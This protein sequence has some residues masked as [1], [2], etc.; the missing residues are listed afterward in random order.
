M[1]VPSLPFSSAAAP[2]AV[3]P[4]GFAA[5]TASYKTVRPSGALHRHVLIPYAALADVPWVR[6]GQPVALPHLDALLQRLRAQDSVP[7]QDTDFC[8]S[9]ERMAALWLGW[10][11]ARSAATLPWAAQTAQVSVE[12]VTPA[13]HWAYMTPCHWTVGAD[14][15]RLD[16]PADLALDAAQSQAF[17]ALLKPW[18]AEDGLRLHYLQPDCWLVEGDVLQGLTS[19]ALDRALLRDVRHWAPEAGQNRTIQ[20]LHSEVQMLLYTHPL[21]LER[22]AKGQAA[23]NA[24]WLHGLGQL[25]TGCQP[26]A[27][28]LEVWDLLRE[29]ALLEGPDAWLQAWQVLDGGPMADLLRHVQAGGSATL[30]LCGERAARSFTTAPRSLGQRLQNLLRPQRFADI[31]EAL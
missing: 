10:P 30:A 25:P 7:V 18:F 21:N 9:Y 16:N 4:T 1:P 29:P 6:Q 12:S 27:T 8:T 26:Q 17:L 5:D 19:A 11:Q 14:Q 3:P 31:R 22:E 20:R 2:F 13:Q 24:F 23:V 28:H 15:I